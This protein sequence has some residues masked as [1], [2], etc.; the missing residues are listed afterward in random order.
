[1]REMIVVVTVASAIVCAINAGQRATDIEKNSPGITAEVAQTTTIESALTNGNSIVS[2]VKYF[3]RQ[4]YKASKQGDDTVTVDIMQ[5]DSR[6]SKLPE[7]ISILKQR[8]FKIMTNDV[9]AHGRTAPKTE[10]TISW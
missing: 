7:V 1:M 8:G 6:H 2:L 5:E 4:I 10:V 9:P 3:E